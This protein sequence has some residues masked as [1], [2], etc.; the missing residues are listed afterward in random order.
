M[1]IHD[2]HYISVLKDAGHT[3][4]SAL[5][6]SLVLDR[7]DHPSIPQSGYLLMLFHVLIHV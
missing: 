1:T 5:F 6:H 3:L 4:K 7:R 2:A